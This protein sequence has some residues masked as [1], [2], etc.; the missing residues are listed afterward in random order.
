MDIREAIRSS[1]LA[2]GFNSEQIDAVCAIAEVRI[3]EDGQYLMTDVD[4]DQDLFLILKGRALMLSVTGE[5]IGH[6]TEGM[7]IGEISFIDQLPRS[8]GVVSEGG[9]QVAVFDA[10][11]MRAL[12]NADLGMKLLALTNITKV[13]CK[14]LRSA[15]RNISALMVQEESDF[16]PRG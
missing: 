13:L 7:P 8:L 6:V 10:E 15:N 5:V 1:Q 4:V 2:A 11:K 14:R 16:A 3:L 12:M 9:T